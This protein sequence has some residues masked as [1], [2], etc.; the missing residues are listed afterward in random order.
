MAHLPSSEH[1]LHWQQLARADLDHL[2]GLLTAIEHVDEP[3]ERHSVEELYERFDE[4]D[5]D[6]EIDTIL[7]RDA[8][9][10]PVAYGWARRVAFDVDPRRVYLSGGVHPGWRRQGIGT[11][12]L[13][14]QIDAARR[15]YQAGPVDGHGPLRVICLAEEK[16]A[17]HRRL[18]TARGL[19]AIRWFTDFTHHFTGPL[20]DPP[21]PAGIDIVPMRDEHLEAVRVAHN[22]AFADHWGS[23]P[24]DAA[25]W[26][27][28]LNR[29]STRLNWSWVAVENRSGDVV[30]YVTNGS[31]EQDW[32][33]QG[34]KD[35]WT[36]R[37]GVRPAWRRRGIARAL[38]AASMRSYAEAGLDAAGLGVDTDN[39][40]GA[41]GLYAEMGFVATN[42]TVLYA[43]TETLEEVSAA[44]DEGGV[45]DSGH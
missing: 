9:G 39:P 43:R 37:L 27:E 1:R 19:E 6:P 23:Q 2:S 34:F 24:I 33:A 42:T 20:P 17:G 7:G 12:L 14:W 8:G 21:I 32:A 16:L 36:V 44:L 30:G 29:S 18:Y 35:G 22:E 13:R 28:E 38:L 25:H 15:W 3:I 11:S 4:I 26:F 41:Y 5:S 40:T 31:Y 45:R 10:L